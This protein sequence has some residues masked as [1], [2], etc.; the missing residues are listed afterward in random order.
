MFRREMDLQ[1]FA[2]PTGQSRSERVIQRSGRVRIQIIHD[3]HNLLRVRV[4]DLDQV[5]HKVRPS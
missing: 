3:Q 4:L 1:F 2:Q 5:L